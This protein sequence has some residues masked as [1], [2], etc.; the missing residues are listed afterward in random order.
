MDIY[1]SGTALN[2]Q[3]QLVTNGGR[4]LAVSAWDDT[5]EKAIKIATGCRWD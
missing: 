3:E 4:V 2:N 5:L 1:H